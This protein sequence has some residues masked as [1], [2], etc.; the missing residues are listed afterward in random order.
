M[1]LSALL[2]YPSVITHS[3]KFDFD[4]FRL[5]TTTYPPRP[6]FGPG[7]TDFGPGRPDFGPGRPD[8]GPGRPDFGQR[9]LILS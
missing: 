3:S 7:R 9:C 1:S 8:F 4:V 6:D 5:P 2:G